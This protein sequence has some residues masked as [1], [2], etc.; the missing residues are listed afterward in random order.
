MNK[1]KKI[2]RIILPIFI[3]V[4]LVNIYFFKNEA[5]AF[6]EENNKFY[7]DLY[8][9]SLNVEKLKEKQMPIILDFGVSSCVP[10]INMKDDLEKLFDK[11]HN[12]ASILFVD[13]V[14]YPELDNDFYVEVVP[15]QVFFTAEGLPFIPSENLKEEITGF[16]YEYDENENIVNTYHQGELT[17]EQLEKILKEMGV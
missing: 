15:T 17:F 14:K 7:S 5:Y 11:Y 13:A 8:V 12:Q 2:L 9:N 6:S 16:I 10:C 4:V 3:V 1:S